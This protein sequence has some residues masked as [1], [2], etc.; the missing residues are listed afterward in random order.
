MRYLT[1]SIMSDAAAYKAKV[2]FPSMS[3]WLL[4]EGGARSAFVTSRL[5]INV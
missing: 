3:F 4:F 5:I 1:F 2:F